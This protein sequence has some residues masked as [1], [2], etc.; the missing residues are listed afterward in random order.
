VSELD[1]AWAQALAEAQQRARAAGRGDV[2]AYLSLRATNDL[3]RAT[4]IEWL[5]NT[6][7]TV[8]ARA[9]RRGGSIQIARVDPHRFPVGNSTMVGRLLKL[10]LRVRD[11]T[12]EA[13][14]PRTPSDGIVR[15]GGLACA[16]V[17]H[18]GRKSVNQELLLIRP[19]RGAPHWMIADKTSS[20]EG[21][22]EAEI[23]RH[24]EILLRD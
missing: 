2:A 11:L 1:E 9:N 15:G 12:I 21:F 22:L 6:F 17:K 13:G 16:Q 10:S 19:A 5:M 14:W 23:Q 8:A 18:L 24:I 4:S 3:V 20:R 7:T